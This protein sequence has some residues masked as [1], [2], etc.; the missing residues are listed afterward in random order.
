MLQYESHHFCTSKYSLTKYCIYIMSIISL[1]EYNSIK[2][3]GV[4]MKPAPCVTYFC[5]SDLKYAK[6]DLKIVKNDA[7]DPLDGPATTLH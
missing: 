5:Q 1:A 4:P 7:T 3:C 2:H 6:N